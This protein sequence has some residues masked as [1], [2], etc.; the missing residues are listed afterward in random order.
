MNIFIK[1]C[2]KITMVL[3]EYFLKSNFALSKVIGLYLSL[4]INLYVDKS[5][6]DFLK[7]KSLLKGSKRTVLTGTGVLIIYFN[8]F[9][10]KYPLG[11]H[12]RNALNKEYQN[13]IILKENHQLS[14][15]VNYYLKQQDNYYIMEKLFNVDNLM[16]DYKY[17]YTHLS[18]ITS[19][20][21]TM[22][23]VLEKKI[24]QQAFKLIST[25]TEVLETFLEEREKILIISMHGDLTQYNIMKNKNNEVS[26]IDLDRFTMNGFL[27][28]DRIHFTVE[29]Y[30]KKKNS[31][32]FLIIQNFLLKKNISYESLFYLLIYF[33]YRIGIENDERVILPRIY[34]EEINR[35]IFQFIKVIEKGKKYE[36]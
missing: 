17:V 12:S 11:C 14:S 1:I 32:Y 26:L 21:I 25:S 15:L 28:L 24:F 10:I 3:S 18:K 13:Y 7:I 4:K 27:Y 20:P 30:A 23:E 16:L 2:N 34:Y 6:I 5:F 29:Y 22:F 35:T 8:D 33:L 36:I 31:N 19:T 9:I